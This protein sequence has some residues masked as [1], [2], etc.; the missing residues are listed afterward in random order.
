MA[1]K[2]DSQFLTYKG[3]PLVRSGK[4]LYY[5]NMCDP[6]VIML[7]ICS[8]KKVGDLDV[9]S[10]VTVQLLNT[11]PNVRP[12]EKIVKKS[13]KQGLYQAMDI[14]TIWLDRALSQ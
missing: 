4:T 13:E 9:A 14:A 7:Q 8:T 2:K 5:G 12:R 10:R 1:G 3:R 6:Y 11:D